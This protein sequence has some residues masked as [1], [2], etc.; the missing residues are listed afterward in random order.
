M[1]KAAEINYTEIARRCE[2]FQNGLPR[3]DKELQLCGQTLNET[4]PNAQEMIDDLSRAYCNTKD[5]LQ[6]AIIYM[7]H[8]L[9]RNEEPLP[10]RHFFQS[11]SRIVLRLKEQIESNPLSILIQ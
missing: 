4:V 1:E 10:V 3:V 5:E 9:P 2:E 8:G 6:S 7:G 11:I